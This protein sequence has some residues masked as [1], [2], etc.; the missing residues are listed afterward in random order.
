[1][2]SIDFTG[3]PI[4]SA[5]PTPFS[6]SRWRRPGLGGAITYQGRLGDRWSFTFRTPLMPIEPD[7]RRWSALFDDAERLGGVFDIPQPEFSVGAPGTVLVD[8]DTASGRTVPL[9]GLTPSYAIK[10]G[11]WI[12]F[13]SDGYRYADR[14]VEQVIADSTG[15]ATVRIRNLLRAPLS[16]DD[17]VELGSPKIEGAVEVVSRPPL[18]IEHVTAIEFIVTEFR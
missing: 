9:K 15:D 11:Q 3:L 6:F 4:A 12:S 18:E 1:M 14:V 7:W 2:A 8:A 10:A 17:V 16:E 5:V 13:V